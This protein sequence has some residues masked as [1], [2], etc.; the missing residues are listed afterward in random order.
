MKDL[1]QKALR[2]GVARISAQVA[3]LVIRMGSLMIMARLL[4]PQEFGLVGMVTAVTGV[5]TVFR[6]FGLSAATVQRATITK[7]QSST[8]FWINLGIGVF[9]GLVMLALAPAVVHFYHEPRLFA[10]TA[11]M[12]SAF[13]A[14]AAG[15]QHAALLE[16]QLRF[17][18]LAFIDIGSLIVSTAI[19]ITMAKYGFGYWALV[20]SM[21][22]IPF[23]YTLGLW[24]ATKWVPG[25]PHRG[26]GIRSMLHFGG[27][28]TLNG[29]ILYFSNNLDKI[30]L[31]RFWGTDA[32]G[33]YGRAYQL[34]NIP[35]DNLNSAAGGVAF[36]ALS[37]IQDDP[38]RLRDYFLKGYSLVL[39]VSIPITFTCGLFATEMIR[40]FLG[41]KWGSAV[42]VFRLLA[43]TA[44]SFAILMPLGWLITALGMVV[45]ALKMS[46]VFAPL[47]A[48]AYAVGLS[49]GPTGVALAFS[50][51]KL[52][53]VLPLA[54]WVT[55]GTIVSLRDILVAVGRPLLAGIVGLGAALPFELFYSSHLPAL[56][57]LCIGLTIFVSAY[58][59]VLIFMLGQKSL[60][61][62]LFR[63]LLDKKRGDET[64]QASA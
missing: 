16:R 18:T 24:I 61:L 50:A 44:L 29:V 2:G 22:I 45:R 32:L 47:M 57:S 62:S 1:K 26:M 15:V 21:S 63:G 8:L 55:H 19:G 28:L 5:F 40:V 31:G 13:A 43:P 14:N 9:L 54:A 6:D 36:A 41:A 48:I 11:V 42:P 7:E 4:G 33:I 10:I 23:G 20:A 51:M 46:L 64:V 59:A 34:I 49:H 37:R 17:T 53:S 38:P 52:L 39:S 12:A 30:L 27:A 60:Y 25:R 3:N 58:A 56:A 35:T